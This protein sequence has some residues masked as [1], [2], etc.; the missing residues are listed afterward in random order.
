MIDE[1][2]E[3]PL[4]S[5]TGDTQSEVLER[6]PELN[7]AE[8]LVMET[9]FLDDLVDVAGARSMGHIHLTEVLERA[10]L[11]PR[12]DVV[13]SHFSARYRN[14]DVHRIVAARLPEAL[15]PFVRVFG[16]GAAQT[17]GR[18]A[19]AAEDGDGREQG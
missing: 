17:D 4:L 9:T 12:T 8:T 5:F 7:R 19:V 16:V 6:T 1:P 13:L 18:R 3:V 15:R 2:Y 14:D 11:L 10:A